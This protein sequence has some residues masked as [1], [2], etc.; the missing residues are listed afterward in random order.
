LDL[1]AALGSAPA[2]EASEW[3]VHFH[4]PLYREKLEEF[5]NTQRYLSDVLALQKAEPFTDHIEVETY[6]WD[7]LPEAQRALGLHA[8]I[9]RELAWVRERL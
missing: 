6:T 9:A 5:A 2:L 3:R 1:P 8:S 4:V 7:V